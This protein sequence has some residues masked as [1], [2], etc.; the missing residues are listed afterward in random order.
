MRSYVGPFPVVVTRDLDGELHVF[1]NR[2]AHRGVEFCREYRG[3]AD[4]F[5]CPYHNWTYDLKGDL[6]AIP[7]RRGVKG[8]GGAPKD[9]DMSEFGL[10]RFHVATRGGVIFAPN[11]KCRMAEHTA[12][13][14]R[15]TGN[16]RIVLRHDGTV[17]RER[18]FRN[19]PLKRFG[20]TIE[21]LLLSLIH[22]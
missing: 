17:F 8:L 7:F 4:S 13:E 16:R 11:V 19:I 10:R 15:N 3:K 20:E 12:D 6:T 9:F 22:I 1:E 14:D 5:I 2:C 18:K 21:N